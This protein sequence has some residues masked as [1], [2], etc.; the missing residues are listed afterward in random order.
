MQKKRFDTVCTVDAMGNSKEFVLSGI[1]HLSAVD[2]VVSQER[3]EKI[4]ARI[5]E[6]HSFA[7]QAFCDVDADYDV[8]IAKC[9][10]ILREFLKHFE[11]KYVMQYI[12]SCPGDFVKFLIATD[13]AIANRL[14]LKQYFI[15]T[16]E[17]HV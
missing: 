13:H 6:A 12:S 5:L 14:F 16:A 11:I 10:R 7:E 3:F 4:V 2:G 1:R 17:V 8:C 9:S 15:D